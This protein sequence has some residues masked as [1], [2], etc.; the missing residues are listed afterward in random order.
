MLVNHCLSIKLIMS[1]RE[2]S[3]CVYTGYLLYSLKMFAILVVMT[4]EEL[5]QFDGKV[6][7]LLPNAHFRVVLDNGHQ[8][9]AHTSGRMRKNRIRIL[10]GDK[11]KVEMTPYDLTK[12]RVI[13]RG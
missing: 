11:V 9:I 7:E 2:I 3:C 4:K 13:H 6:M 1:A 12:G 10:A 5:L 8:I